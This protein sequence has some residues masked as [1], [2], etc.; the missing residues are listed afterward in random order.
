[1]TAHSP[2]ARHRY[3]TLYNRLAILRASR[4]HSLSSGPHVFG[5]RLPGA[6]S[7]DFRLNRIGTSN[8]FP[9]KLM[10]INSSLLMLYPR[11][12]RFTYTS[13][14]SS[15]FRPGRKRSKLFIQS[16]FRAPVEY[17]PSAHPPRGIVSTFGTLPDTARSPL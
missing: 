11:D 2:S 17:A 16:N 5:M 8:F 14:A 10:N 7:M 1:M 15:S 13:R 3:S 12:F 6:Y 4:L 9:L